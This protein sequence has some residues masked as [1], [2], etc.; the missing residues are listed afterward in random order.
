MRISVFGL[1]Y[2]G[3]VTAA[4]LAVGGHGVIGV[5]IASDKVES[6]NSGR[7]PIVE[8]GIDLI[9]AQ[10][11]E[12]GHL[13][14]TH[15]TEDAIAESDLA[16]VCVGTPS[17]ENG[18]L[19]T[20]YVER[21]T[22]Q[23]GLA[24][25]RDRK[26]DFLFVLRSTVLPG[27]TRKIV[28]PVLEQTTGRAAGEGYDVV[29]HPEFLREGSSVEDFHHPPKIV[30]G[31]RSAGTSQ[32]LQQLYECFQAPRF[33]MGLEVAE[34]IKYADNSFHAVK[35]AFANEIG[36]FCR[37]HDI[38]GREVMEVFCA[39]RQLNISPAYL[40]PGFAFGGSCLPKDVQ[41]L[42][43]QARHSDINLPMLEG[44]MPSNNEQVERVFRRIESCRPSEIGFVGLAFKPGT[45]DLRE[46]PLV[47]LA[48]RLL[49]RGHKLS[50][51]DADVQAA[52]LVGG[53]LTYVEQRLPHLSGL[54]VLSLDDLSR[55]DVIVMGHPLKEESLLDRWLE[56][57]K[58]VLDLVGRQTRTG[59]PGYEGLHW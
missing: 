50:I 25:C 8:R 23:I 47:T 21:V 52:R 41:A 2:V 12:S 28:L 9:I 7:S 20:E 11:V 3:T 46:S 18:S 43:Y 17:A 19:N 15:E 14:A 56:E 59:H 16:I 36:R 44:V 24:L 1:G 27:T 30:I 13:R 39:D 26:K 22:A 49:G 33:V 35:I 57:G 55:C 31:E 4:C 6:I 53:N 5:D 54:L 45:D 10:T 42:L 48:E 34:M 38:D 51:C 37:S 58:K 32:P 40:R 29:F